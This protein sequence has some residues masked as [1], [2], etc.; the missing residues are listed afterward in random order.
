MSDHVAR[1]VAAVEARGESV[2][3]T[4]ASAGVARAINVEIQRRRH[5]GRADAGP[6]LADGTRALVGDRVATRR[7]TPLQT[8]A[9]VAVRNRQTW[10]VTEVGQ[11]GSV[12]VADGE[13]GSVRLPAAYVGR[14]TELGWAVTGYGTQGITADHGIA[15]VEPSST[16]NGIYV[17]MTRGRGR[18]VAWVL[19][20]SGLADAEEALAAAVARPANALSAHAIAARLGAP[21]PAALQEDPA[22]RAPVPERR[23]PQVSPEPPELPEPAEEGL[24]ERMARR[25]AEM[26]GRR[27]PARR[28]SS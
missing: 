10:T 8:S 21:V 26:G 25:L 15:V 9:G 24:P 5:L 2:A 1:Q 3:V 17:A 19:D 14:H 4:C 16:R 7:N 12:V 18:N 27:P 11:D 22:V 13:R 28:L 6:A 20:R 23:P